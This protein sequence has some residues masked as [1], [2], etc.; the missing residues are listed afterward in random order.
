MENQGQPV[1]QSGNGKKGS[2]MN[3]IVGLLNSIPEKIK[4]LMKRDKPSAPA[5]TPAA[6]QTEP[7]AAPAQVEN[8]ATSTVSNLGK[9]K[10]IIPKKL[11]G[12]VV[13]VVVLLIVLMIVMKVLTGSGSGILP[14]NTPSPSPTATPVTEV[15][16]QYA[17]D[18]DV[19]EIKERMEALD[20]ELNS[21]SFRDDRLR[22]PSLDW[23]V[24]FE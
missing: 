20:K 15:P 9:P 19:A 11:I 12:I 16:S 18:Q 10:I 13:A 14:S 3:S 23:D 5:S 4:G 21:A 1:Y 7:A 2:P 6:V 8:S 22:V 17:D 24:S